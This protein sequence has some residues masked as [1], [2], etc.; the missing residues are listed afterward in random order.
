M[1]LTKIAISEWA[2]MDCI[3]P[4][5]EDFGEPNSMKN[6]DVRVGCKIMKL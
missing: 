1:P 5:V 2:I 3:S 4:Q 6:C